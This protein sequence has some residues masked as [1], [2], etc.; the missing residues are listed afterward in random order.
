ML[1]HPSTDGGICVQQGIVLVE[2]YIGGRIQFSTHSSSVGFTLLRRALRRRVGMLSLERR[3]NS[4][5]KRSLNYAFVLWIESII[6]AQW[7]GA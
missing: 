1:E 7:S 3:S 2:T 4:G 6:Q 5:T